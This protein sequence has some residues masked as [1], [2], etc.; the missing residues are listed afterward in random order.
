L[1]NQRNSAEAAAQRVRR[2]GRSAAE[3]RRRIAEDAAEIQGAAARE[4]AVRAEGKHLDARVLLHAHGVVDRVEHDDFAKTGVARRDRTDQLEIEGLRIRCGE[5]GS[6][7][8][9]RRE[10]SAFH[11]HPDFPL[12][13]QVFRYG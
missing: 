10:W 9:C 8:C 1:R 13:V 6:G 7:N 3:G 4:G 11:C 2:G 5:D 12:E